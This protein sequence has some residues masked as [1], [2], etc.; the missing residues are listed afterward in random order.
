MWSGCTAAFSLGVDDPGS[1][2]LGSGQLTGS[3][4][5]FNNTNE[6]TIRIPSSPCCPLFFGTQ[7]TPARQG[8][9]EGWSSPSLVAFSSH[10]FRSVSFVCVCRYIRPTAGVEPGL[11][12]T[13]TSNARTDAVSCGSKRHRYWMIN[14][15]S[16]RHSSLVTSDLVTSRLRNG[17]WRKMCSTSSSVSVTKSGDLILI[18]PILLNSLCR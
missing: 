6:C 13:F 11:T 4:T 12:S 18:G 3:N 16:W 15:F 14:L 17:S 10:S 8:L 5:L 2:T 9:V 1:L 7:R